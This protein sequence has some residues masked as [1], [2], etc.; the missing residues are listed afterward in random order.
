[1][2]W[3]RYFS[4]FYDMEFLKKAGLGAMVLGV[5]LIIISSIMCVLLYLDS[6]AAADKVRETFILE[7]GLAVA[8]GAALLA[9]LAHYLRE[10]TNL[11]CFEFY[12]GFAQLLAK[13]AIAVIPLTF[14][15]E[16][17]HLV[18]NKDQGPGSVME[19]VKVSLEVF[20]LC[21]VGLAFARLYPRYPA[22]TWEKVLDLWLDVVANCI[23][24]ALKSPNKHVW[25][26]LLLCLLMLVGFAFLLASFVDVSPETNYVATLSLAHLTPFILVRIDSVWRAR[27]GVRTSLFSES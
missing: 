4:G 10:N 16:F 24:S 15:Y 19:R 27:D 11:R 20:G 17:A 7:V 2:T 6:L 23:K 1:M 5:A 12:V 9:A 25:G 8:S 13:T 14:A 3:R 18:A 21:S 26:G 22:W